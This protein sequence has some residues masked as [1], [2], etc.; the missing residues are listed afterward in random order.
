MTGAIVGVLR[1]TVNP[2]DLLSAPPTIPLVYCHINGFRRVS[3]GGEA[4]DLR[5]LSTQLLSWQAVA[6]IIRV[7]LRAA[8]CRHARCTWRPREGAWNAHNTAI[9]RASAR[10]APA[11][12]SL[13]A[14]KVFQRC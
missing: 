11:G 6:G 14:S 8:L 13:Q 3:R 12:V 7:K 1:R 10:R 4:I 5:Y 9:R 2:I